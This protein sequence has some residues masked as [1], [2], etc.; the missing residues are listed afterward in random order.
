VTEPTAAQTA[1]AGK[2]TRGGLVGTSAVVVGLSVWTALPWWDVALVSVL[3]VL[4]PSLA[5]AQVPLVQGMELD[6]MP[7]Y[8][9][10]VVTLVVLG[11]LA[12][13]AGSVGE[14]VTGVGIVPLEALPLV[15]WS[16]GLAACGLLVL[17]GFRRLA[18][19][20]G[21]HETAI[22]EALIPRT[23]GERAVFGVL[24]VAAGVGEELA[25][26]GYL[27]LAVAPVVGG[28]GALVLS[29]FVFGVLH[30]YQGALG[31]MRT[32]LM[33]GVLGVGF[34]LSGSLWPAIVGH[35][36]V[37]VVAGVLLADRFMVPGA[38]SGVA[39]IR[40]HSPD[41]HHE[42]THGSRSRTPG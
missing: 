34:L 35:A 31:M 21:W 9:G 25:Y 16:V 23:N 13:A 1:L 24:S 14:G 11:G 40:G 30:A 28:V 39:F 42:R 2:V 38:V 27:I 17:D 33:G 41:H 37:D 3:M 20:R 4:L 29:S 15:A 18:V 36:L 10:S 32:A 26:R 12:L 6:R 7:V 22:L 8:L 5:L 19:R